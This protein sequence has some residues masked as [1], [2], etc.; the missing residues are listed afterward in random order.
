M[1]PSSPLSFLQKKKKQVCLYNLEYSAASAFCN[2]LTDL[3]S[4]LHWQKKEPSKSKDDKKKQPKKK[5]KKKKKT[6]KSKRNEENQV[7]IY[8]EVPP[9]FSYYLLMSL[10]PLSLSLL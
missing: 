6:P 1:S 8:H 7:C 5:K 9:Y 10:L 2:S 3:S 4:P